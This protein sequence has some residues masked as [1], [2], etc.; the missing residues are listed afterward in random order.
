VSAVISAD[1]VFRY[2]LT[3]DIPQ[4]P[5]FGNSGRPLTF[6]MLN[7]STADSEVDDPT[8]RR[9]R[10]FAKREGANQLIVVNVYALRSTDPQKL[11]LVPDPVGPDNF[12]HVHRA[13]VEAGRVVV[14]WG[15]NARS[16]DV[17][18]TMFELSKSGAKILCLGTTKAGHPRHPLY[19]K[20]DQPLI[21][22]SPR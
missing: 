17:E 3:R 21:P 1:G 10:G 2:R 9:C 12:D 11:F 18:N 13:A 20:G 4:V 16:E 5:I 15:V 19:V 6:C 22:W 14:A 7:P 8:I